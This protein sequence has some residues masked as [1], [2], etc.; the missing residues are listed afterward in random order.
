MPSIVFSSV[1]FSYTTAHTVVSDADFSLGPGWTGLVGDNGSGKSTLL[2]LIAGRLRPTRGEIS[3]DSAVP[4]LLCE[5]SVEAYDPSIRSFGDSWDP[6]DFA[7]RGRLDL[8]PEQLVRWPTL[9]PGERKRWQIGAALSSRP[10]ILLLDEPTNH[11][12]SESRDLLTGALERFSGVG[13]LVSHD[14]ELLDVDHVDR[15]H[16]WGKCAALDGLLLGGGDPVA[17][18]G[19]SGRG[20]V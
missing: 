1:S 20:T 8:D 4:P 6:P 5:Q 16:R 7:L 9:S 10:D 13:M 17:S 11:L 19:G 18:T 15:A 3:I 14:R 2:S 12:D